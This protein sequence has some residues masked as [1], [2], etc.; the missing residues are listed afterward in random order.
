MTFRIPYDRLNALKEPPKSDHFK[1]FDR[2][3]TWKNR[4][5]TRIATT[6]LQLKYKKSKYDFL[7]R[8]N[9]CSPSMLESHIE[10]NKNI[11]RLVP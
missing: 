8:F 7:L 9:A 10:S 6:V 2:L 5:K 1:T 3:T 11:T 4:L